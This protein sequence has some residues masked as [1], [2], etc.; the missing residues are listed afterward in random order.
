MWQIF[1]CSSG[2]TRGSTGWFIL[3]DLRILYML[4]WELEFILDQSKLVSPKHTHTSSCEAEPSA[5]TLVVWGRTRD[6]PVYPLR[7]LRQV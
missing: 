6:N 3:T 7:R 5:D 4:V 1:V 2:Q